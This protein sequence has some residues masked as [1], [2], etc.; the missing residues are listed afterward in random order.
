MSPLNKDMFRMISRNG[1]RFLAMICII[2]VGICFVTGVGGI[3]PKLAGSVS[4]YYQSRA[5]ADIDIKA[6]NPGGFSDEELKTIRNWKDVSSAEAMTQIDDPSGRT[7]V[8]IYPFHGKINKLKVIKG[9]LPQSADEVVVEQ[10]GKKIKKRK[11]GDVIMVPLPGLPGPDGRENT[12]YKKVK[13]VGIVSSPL[14]L[15]LEGDVNIRNGKYLD[16]AVYFSDE[17]SPLSTPEGDFTP[18]TDVM[19]KLSPTDEY[20]TDS[21]IDRAEAIGRKLTD[22]LEKVFPEK[23]Y[24]YLTLDQNP[25]YRAVKE[26]CNKIDVIAQAFP[27]FFIL[28]VGLVTLTNMSRMAEEERKN[29]GCLTSLGYPGKRITG[30][31]LAFALGGT[32]A[33]EALGLVSGVFI[34]PDVIYNA[35]KML[36]FLPAETPELYPGLGIISSALMILAVFVVTS[37]VLYKTVSEVPARLFQPKSAKPGKKILLERTGLLWRSL[38]FKYKSAWRN[39]FRFKGRF[40]M[41][42]LSVTGST[43]L[44]VAGL[45]LRDAAMA[46]NLPEMKTMKAISVAVII[47]ALLLSI[48]VLYN[49]TAMNIGERRREIAT[50]EVLGYQMEEVYGFIYREIMIM[51]TIGIILGIPAGMAFLN[52][53][54]VMMDFSGLS[55]VKTASYLLAFGISEAF[56]SVVMVLTRGQIRKVDMN[57]SLKS[58]E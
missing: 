36:I 37:I 24:E 17:H 6:K 52:K 31:Y 7:R 19:V 21:Y 28:V 15:S 58:G 16:T 41:I 47:F 12:Q 26:M 39:I 35:F 51:A 5:I 18:K 45:G 44:V 56:A 10:P 9:R 23:D 55:D 49:I 22:E 29:I 48:L 2:A 30:E 20:F 32:V 1:S 4:R 38:S 54:F 3:T 46:E 43:M 34:L 33:G 13:V 14:F 40:W 42:V 53:I 27:A 57:D 11:T 25:G 50:L 8:Y